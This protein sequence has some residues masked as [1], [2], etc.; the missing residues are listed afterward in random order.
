MGEY[1]FAIFRARGARTERLYDTAYRYWSTYAITYVFGRRLSGRVDVLDAGGRDGGTLRLLENLNLTG[2]YTC[3]DLVPTM[4]RPTR[5][6]FDIEIVQSSFADFR[7]TRKY[8]AV[9]FESSLDCCGDYREIAWLADCLKPGG[10]VVV[11][12]GARGTRPLWY[13]FWDRGGCHVLDRDEIPPAF[14]AIGLK[15]VELFPLLG[16]TS[17]LAHWLIQ[18]KL[19]WY[20]RGVWHKTLARAIPPLARV[21]PMRLPNRILNEITWR[22]DRLLPFWRAG[23]CIVLERAA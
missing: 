7:P 13:G 19:A 11:T 21:D 12:L 2:T 9:L 3:M 8:D 10:F 23:H 1:N 17:R 16:L 14:A 5:S 22:L 18:I 4:V 6:N 15:V 20:C